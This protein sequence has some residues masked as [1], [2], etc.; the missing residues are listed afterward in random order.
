MNTWN[1]MNRTKSR[2]IF[3]SFGVSMFAF[4]LVKYAKSAKRESKEELTLLF[5]KDDLLSANNKIFF[6]YPIQDAYGSSRSKRSE[7][8]R[9][10]DS[11]SRYSTGS[12][13]DSSSTIDEELDITVKPKKKIYISRGES[14]P[15]PNDAYHLLDDRISRSEKRIVNIQKRSDKSSSKSLKTNVGKSLAHF[16]KELDCLKREYKDRYLTPDEI[17]QLENKMDDIENSLFKLEES[18]DKKGL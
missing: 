9:R 16:R 1:F 8:Y 17:R 10:D 14:K 7:N 18:A 5:E 15:N 6:A 12:S 2:N 11:S 3:G 4:L 13:D